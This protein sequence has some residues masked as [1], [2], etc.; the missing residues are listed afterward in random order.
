MITSYL[1]LLELIL[2]TQMITSETC[3]RRDEL[4]LTFQSYLSSE[5]CIEE[6]RFILNEILRQHH[7]LN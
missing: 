2:R 3:T 1:S 4:Q 6:N 5:D 7:W